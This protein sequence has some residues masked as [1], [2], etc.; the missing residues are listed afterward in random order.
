MNTI[1]N[2]QSVGIEYYANLLTSSSKGSDLTEDDFIETDGV[3]PYQRYD[4]TPKDR[5]ILQQYHTILNI[6]VILIFMMDDLI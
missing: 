5:S 3:S 2:D 4:F 6:F 1:V